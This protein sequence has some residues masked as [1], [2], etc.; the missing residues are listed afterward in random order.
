MEWEASFNNFGRLSLFDGFS[1]RNPNSEESITR[2]N[3][4]QLRQSN[5]P[6][7]GW[8]AWNPINNASRWDTGRTQPRQEAY[9]SA[10]LEDD[11]DDESVEENSEDDDGENYGENDGE[12]HGENDGTNGGWNAWNHGEDDG[13]NDEQ[14]DE[15]GEES[16]ENEYEEDEEDEEAARI[17]HEQAKAN[18]ASCSPVLLPYYLMSKVI[19]TERV[20]V[21]WA[22][23]VDQVH[24]LGCATETNDTDP[25]LL[26]DVFMH[27]NH[28]LAL[29][30]LSVAVKGGGKSKLRVFDLVLPLH[31]STFDYHKIKTSTI[32]S[33][34]I[35]DA[36]IR[37]RLPGQSHEV[38]HVQVRL[39]DDSARV[40]TA[41]KRRPSTKESIFAA[42]SDTAHEL[43]CGLFHLSDTSDLSL[44]MATS[45]Y[46][47]VGL[48]AIKLAL[49]GGHIERWLPED[50]SMLFDGRPAMEVSRSDLAERITSRFRNNVG[51]S[52]QPPTETEN[53]ADDTAPAP[54]YVQIPHTPEVD[55]R[56]SRLLN[57]RSPGTL[58]ILKEILVEDSVGSL[59]PAST[60][61]SPAPGA[62]LAPTQTAL[63]P[64]LSWPHWPND[65]NVDGKQGFSGAIPSTVAGTD[66]AEDCRCSH[67][68]NSESNRYG[69]FQ[70][71]H[72]NE[73]RNDQA[74]E[75]VHDRVSRDNHDKEYDLARH[76]AMLQQTSG[77]SHSKH[78]R[79]RINDISPAD[80]TPCYRLEKW[81]NL[82][83]EQNDLVYQLSALERFF[84]SFSDRRDTSDTDLDEKFAYATAVVAC[85]ARGSWRQQ[86]DDRGF[87]ELVAD[88]QALVFAALQRD[89][90][91]ADR[92]WPSFME[93]GSAAPARLEGSF[94][95]YNRIKSRI[96]TNMF[97]KKPV[98]S[99][100]RRHIVDA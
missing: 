47:N 17:L 95:E 48:A 82:A 70:Q 86:L 32:Q 23:S 85:D 18:W 44:Y 6:R 84:D 55:R 40:V 13:E 88:I 68:A 87:R 81:L 21:T 9:T 30:R 92:M 49:T 7:L 78:K 28:M 100:H 31:S 1:P 33:N 34:S 63:P 51:Q 58:E 3:Q 69:R 59:G 83:L 45:M 94:A 42:T 53:C 37:A 43:L 73:K 72:R 96:L 91:A 60:R 79:R 29:L 76:T 71:G 5:E 93:L 50:M 8:A 2:R 26:F 39:T 38:Y 24:G 52:K 4:F 74:L 22:D 77:T 80:H 66:L 19:L 27:E 75:A 14:D 67:D 11:N 10:P 20:V 46:A 61:N 36:I 56:I 65:I 41:F 98:L 99:E 97:A 64:V 90:C 15:D 62:G 16:D 25:E 57:Q 89:P 54:P 12:T 35:R